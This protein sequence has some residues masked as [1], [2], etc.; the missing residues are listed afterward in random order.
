MSDALPTQLVDLKY[1]TEKHG[2]AGS[3]SNDV[4]FYY[5]LATAPQTIEY[6]LKTLGPTDFYRIYKIKKQDARDYFQ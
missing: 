6:H 3:G 4:N 1:E 2:Y 5:L